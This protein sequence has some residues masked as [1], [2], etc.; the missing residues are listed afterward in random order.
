[1]YEYEIS[2]SVTEMAR[3]RRALPTEMATTADHK[4]VDCQKPALD[5]LP[6]FF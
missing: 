6:T 1:M 4:R 2:V 3:W 5:L